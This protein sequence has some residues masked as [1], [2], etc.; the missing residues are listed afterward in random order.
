M[1]THVD[2]FLTR[3]DVASLIGVSLV[4]LDRWAKKTDFPKPV[5][6]GA[7]VRYL[8]SEIDGWIQMTVAATR[9]KQKG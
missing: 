2:R 6:L 4:T 7:R 8:E 1:G 3:K 9:S 5:S